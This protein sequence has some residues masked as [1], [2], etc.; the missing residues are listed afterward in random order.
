M[1]QPYGLCLQEQI[2]RPTKV[3]ATRYEPPSTRKNLVALF[4]SIQALVL[5]TRQT[6]SCIS[7]LEAES[8][9]GP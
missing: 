9:V 8:T 4:V 1:P 5:V 2:S 7:F 6:L 3:R